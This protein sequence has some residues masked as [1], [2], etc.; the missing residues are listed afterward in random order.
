[1]I[2]DIGNVTKQPA[3]WAP[4]P[5]AMVIGS[6]GGFLAGF[7]GGI[8]KSSYDPRPRPRFC[9]RICKDSAA[10]GRSSG[11]RKTPGLS[12]PSPPLP[13]RSRVAESE[14]GGAGALPPSRP[15]RKSDRIGGPS[16]RGTSGVM[17]SSISLTSAS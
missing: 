8:L 2:T 14:T 1:M 9:T 11:R 6:A 4:S 3:E 12:T 17:A 7:L 15:I 13:M 5:S 16:T 10:V